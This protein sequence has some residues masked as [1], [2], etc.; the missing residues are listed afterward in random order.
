MAQNAQRLSIE[1]METDS[2]AIK[3]NRRTVA[4]SWERFCITCQRSPAVLPCSEFPRATLG[5]LAGPAS[6]ADRDSKTHTETLCKSFLFHQVRG[7]NWWGRRER[8]RM[9]RVASVLGC[10]GLEGTAQGS[11][12][13]GEEGG[14]STPRARESAR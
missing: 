14:R 12:S 2:Q 8:G 7:P 6:R 10:E 4:P 1:Q 3:G 5:Q 13:E 11:R 9:G